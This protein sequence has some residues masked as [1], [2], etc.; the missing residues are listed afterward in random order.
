MS[1]VGQDMDVR[2]LVRWLGAAGARAGLRESRHCTIDALMTA[3]QQ[4]SVSV[5][6]KVTRVKLIDELVR[7]ASRRI[8]KSMDELFEME[9]DELVRYFDDVNVETEELLELL[10]ELDVKVRYKGRRRIVDFVARE[11]SETGRFRRIARNETRPPKQPTQSR[12]S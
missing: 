12:V 10:R 9:R 8:D 2:L 3:A 6:K 11:L 1:S 4:F 7:A 5:G